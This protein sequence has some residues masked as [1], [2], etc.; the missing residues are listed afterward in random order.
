VLVH[1][2]ITAGTLEE[3]I[4]RMLS[5]KLATTEEILNDNAEKSLTELSND[6]LLDLIRL[7][8]QHADTT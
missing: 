1:T 3:K 5:E 4:D 7:D 2:F 8:L 6:E